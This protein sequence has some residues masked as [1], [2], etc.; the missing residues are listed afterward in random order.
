MV[1][2]RALQVPLLAFSILAHSSRQLSLVSS[3]GSIDPAAYHHKALRLLIPRL[4]D[5][6]EHLDENVLAAIVVLRNYE[7]LTGRD[8]I[9]SIPGV[10]SPASP[11]LDAGTHLSG[12]TQLLNSVSHFMGDDGLGEAAAWIG[13]RLDMYYSF[14]KSQP[15][16]TRL[17][18]FAGSVSFVK[19]TAEAVANRIIHICARIL[20]HAFVTQKPP[21]QEWARLHADVQEWY[22]AKPWQGRPMWAQEAREGSAFPYLWI[23]NAADG[24][25]NSTYYCNYMYACPRADG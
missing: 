15:L 20:S 22:D 23:N 11:Y 7:E 2:Q 6:V 21:A 24:E 14:T 19:S 4:N 13:L 12:V 18:N 5:P 17:E 3:V 16:R 8:H 25:A 1:P 10:L 9:A